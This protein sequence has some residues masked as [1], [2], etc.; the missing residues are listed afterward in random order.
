MH[1]STIGRQ[2]NAA[3]REARRLLDLARVQVRNRI[4]C[5]M[6]DDTFF[7]RRDVKVVADPE[8]MAIISARTSPASLGSSLMRSGIPRGLP[9]VLNPWTA[10]SAS[11]RWCTVTEEMLAVLSLAWNLTPGRDGRSPWAKLGVD[12]GQGDKPCTSSS[13][14]RPNSAPRDRLLNRTPGRDGEI[15]LTMVSTALRPSARRVRDGPPAND[16]PR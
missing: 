9:P 13:Y 14:S 8:S 12:I 10:A 4:Q 16:E 7:H 15:C 2:L 11:S 3:G 5:L 6:A 1:A